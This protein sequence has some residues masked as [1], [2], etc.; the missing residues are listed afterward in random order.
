M[1]YNHIVVAVDFSE[2]SRQALLE[3]GRLA[4][5]MKS[6]ITGLHVIEEDTARLF[7]QRLHGEPHRLVETLTE[8]LRSWLAASTPGGVETDA[9]VVVG[10]PSRDLALEAEKTGADLWVIGAKGHSHPTHRLG[11]VAGGFAR[12]AVAPRLLVSRNAVVPEIVVACID[13]S[14]TSSRVMDDAISMA[15]QEGVPLEVIHAVA[16]LTQYYADMA[17]ASGLEPFAT[18]SIDPEHIKKI[19]SGQEKQLEEFVR[20]YDSQF[21]KLAVKW[22]TVEDSSPAFAIVAHLNSLQNPLVVLGAH[23]RS[24]LREMIL[25]TTAERVLHEAPCSALL[26][27]GPRAESTE[28]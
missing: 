7:E 25:G 23:G 18:L 12:R 27:R 15:R 24:G 13:Y 8:Q 26:V 16:P 5:R 2:P 14:D 17:V 22:R 10:S 4:E 9:K 3:A 20:G 21:E 1:E 11:A 28:S 19:H 6:S